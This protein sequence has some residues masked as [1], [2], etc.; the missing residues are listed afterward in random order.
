MNE[1]I[2]GTLNNNSLNSAEIIPLYESDNHSI[3]WIGTVVTDEEIPCNSYLLVDEG[4]GYIFE[5]GGLSHFKPTYDK[6]SSIISPFEVSH[7]LLSHQDPDVCASLP[8]WLQFN[9]D[10]KVVCPS[11][12]NRFMPHYMV[13]NVQYLCVPDQGL[14][15]PL[16]SGGQLQCISAPYLHSPG[17]MVVFD[18]ISGFLFS[19]DI[20]AAVANDD[21]FRLVIDDWQQQLAW[22]LGFHQRYM[23]STKAASEFVKSIS[24]LPVAAILPQHGHIFR[25]DEV[26]QFLEW[27][28]V[29]PCGIDYLYP[30]KG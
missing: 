10:L 9:P 7:L 24:S 11:L 3:Y 8:S 4:E 29:L 14:T 25:D 21:V 6:V 23:G 12:W 26:R 18:S 13:Y 19:G 22:M 30:G 1:N 16:K 15:I 5:P 27:F 20:G 17:N 2:L 28:K